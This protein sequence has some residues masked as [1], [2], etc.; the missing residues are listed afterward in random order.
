M[1]QDRAAER[2]WRLLF[3]LHSATGAGS[4][5]R[6]LAPAS[7]VV[8]PCLCVSQTNCPTNAAQLGDPAPKGHSYIAS[9][10]VKLV[11]SA[12][13]RAVPILCDMPRDEVERRFK[14]GWR[15]LH[16][17]ACHGVGKHAHAEVL[18]AHPLSPRPSLLPSTF[19]QPNRRR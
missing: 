12:G 16:Q 13:A 4:P 14:V 17:A 15:L 9:S 5:H 11:E 1:G 7:A 2:R 18:T 10:Y 8:P 6:S 3:C 19:A